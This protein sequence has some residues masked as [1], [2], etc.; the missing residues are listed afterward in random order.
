MDLI[1]I[2]INTFSL[3]QLVLVKSSLDQHFFCLLSF[4][5]LKK[6]S[7][8]KHVIHNIQYSNFKHLYLPKYS[9]Y[10]P[11]TLELLMAFE[12]FVQRVDAQHSRKV[13]F[14]QIFRSVL[15]KKNIQ[16]DFKKAS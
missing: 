5:R 10:M 2:F 11:K 7:K 6:K 13:K 4:V 12:S 8:Y 9:D 16:S 1:N 14:L 3:F 15:C